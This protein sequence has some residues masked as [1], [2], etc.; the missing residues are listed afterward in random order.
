M[1]EVKLRMKEQNKYEIIQGAVCSNHVHLC[2][3][4]PPKESVSNF[5]VYLK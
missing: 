2:L 3:S 4:I 1:K 5:M